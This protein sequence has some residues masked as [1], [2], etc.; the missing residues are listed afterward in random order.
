[1][2]SG[3][4]LARIASAAALL[5]WVLASTANAD[6]RATLIQVRAERLASAGQCSEVV[7]LIGGAP[8]PARSTPELLRLEGNC[9]IELAR[10]D[11]ALATLEAAKA[12]DPTLADLDLLIAIALYHLEDYD[13]SMAALEQARGNTDR[14]AELDLYT[15]LVLLHKRQHR[16]AAL[17]L[18]RARIADPDAVEPAASYYAALA[19]H[20]ERERDR[21]RSA[22]ARVKAVDSEGPW[23]RQ[24]SQALGTETSLDPYWATITVGL[25]YDSNVRLAPAGAFPDKD[26]GR[27]VWA[28]QGGA[29]L[30][31]QED[32]S[33]GIV[34]AYSG[35]AHFDLNVFDTHYPVIGGWVDR[36]FGDDDLLRL[37]YDVGYA[38]VDYDPFLFS[39]YTRASWIHVWETAG[40]TEL[41]VAGEFNNYKFDLIPQTNP[42][43]GVMPSDRDRDGNGVIAG[44]EHRIPL[45]GA[46]SVVRGGYTFESYWS[47]GEEWDADAHSVYVGVS[48]L[49]PWEILFDAEGGYTYAPHDHPTTFSEPDFSPP[50]ANPP[51]ATDDRTD[52]IYTFEVSLEKGVTEHVSVS[53][54]YLYLHSNSN[55][56]FF[57]Y[58]RHIIG[59]YV[60]VALP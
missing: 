26:D 18:E 12:A 24:A 10:Y 9:Q 7:E 52:H 49:L 35:S 14:L 46:S 44:I 42:P 57:D 30:F 54:E 3:Q 4:G 8:E 16:E 39:Q 2:R 51:R 13:G 45:R 56:G 32:W 34:G 53:T 37:R 50:P 1:M 59:A 21:A 11:E 36:R 47:D 20:A 29:R 58:D 19:W 55:A 6:D 40:L 28:V 48:A 23:A 27:A 43:A 25:E 17:A 38:W 33:G 41:F 22:L 15:G 5:T 31:E 60:T